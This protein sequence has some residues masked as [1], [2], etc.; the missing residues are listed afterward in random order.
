MPC[1]HH[2]FELI[3][4]DVF[5][6]KIPTSSGPDVPLFKRFRES[7]VEIDTSQYSTGVEDSY[8]QDKIQNHID[9]INH[10]I[11]KQL[12]S[13]QPREETTGNFWSLFRYLLVKFRAVK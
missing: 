7:W 3:L 10:F 9:D 4:R 11:Q 13:K 6:L 12:D 5:E 2:I 8:V 1:R